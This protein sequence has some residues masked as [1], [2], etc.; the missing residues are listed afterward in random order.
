M[1]LLFISTIGAYIAGSINFATLLLIVLGKEDPR[2]GFSG[3]PGVVNVYRQ[4]GLALAA[5]VLLLDVRRAICVALI[6]THL[7]PLELVPKI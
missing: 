5:V 1:K 6:A 4:G 3:S 7:L 2:K